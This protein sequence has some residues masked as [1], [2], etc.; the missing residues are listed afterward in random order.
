MCDSKGRG[1]RPYYFDGAPGVGLQERHVI[2]GPGVVTGVLVTGAIV[3]TIVCLRDGD[4]AGK[5][6]F[7]YRAAAVANADPMTDLS[8]GFDN[9]LYV[10]W[11]P[12]DAN[13]AFTLTVDEP[14]SAVPVA[15]PTMPRSL[16]T[17]ELNKAGKTHEEEGGSSGGVGL[18]S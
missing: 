9:G 13:A 16:A 5:I 12:A 10:E 18:E 3:G 17:G 15:R 6:I 4:K 7:K 8:L 11:T 2:A 1:S 14:E